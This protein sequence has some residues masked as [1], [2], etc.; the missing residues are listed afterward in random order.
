VG[1]FETPQP[2]DSLW[3]H[4]EYL[5]EGLKREHAGQQA[6]NAGIIF[7]KAESGSVI[8]SLSQA[9]D[10]RFASSDNPTRTQTEAAFAQMFTDMLVFCHIRILG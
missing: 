9:I 3:F 2:I 8:P 4:W 7:A 1:T 10:E 5:E 6:G